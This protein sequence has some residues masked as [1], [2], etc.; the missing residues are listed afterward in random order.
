VCVPAI[1]LQAHRR[2]EIGYRFHTNRVQSKGKAGRPRSRQ[3]K[4]PYNRHHRNSGDRVQGGVG[5]VVTRHGVK[6]QSSSQ[7]ALWSDG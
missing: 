2:F 4:P 1:G 5:E 3:A 6:I 7:K